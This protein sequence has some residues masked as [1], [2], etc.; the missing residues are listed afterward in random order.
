MSET[1]RVEGTGRLRGNLEV[2]P[3][4]GHL[5]EQIEWYS[6]HKARN[7]NLYHSLKALQILAAALVPV[8]TNANGLASSA[9]LIGGLGVFI[10]VAEGIQQLGRFHE[11]WIRYALAAE[12]LKREK[13]LYLSVASVYSAV[14][15]RDT[16][17]AERLEEVISSEA[18]QWANTVRKSP[19]EE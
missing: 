7:R 1:S 19:P 2:H 6:R 16:L 18:S 4:F 5:E 14:E 13:R 12:A 17:L 10:V 15:T 3:A 9:A 11:N 8:L